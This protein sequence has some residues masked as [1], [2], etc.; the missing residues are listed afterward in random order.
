MKKIF[1][2]F[3]T[4]LL[5]NACQKQIPTEQTLKETTIEEFGTGSVPNIRVQICHQNGVEIVIDESALI[6]HLAHGDAVDGD[7]DGYFDR[8]NPCSVIDCNDNNASVNSGATEICENN[9]DDN[10]DGQID[11][12][13]I[14]FVTICNQ[15]WMSKNLDISTYKNG[16]PIPLVT[17]PSEWAA[18][19]TGAYCYYNNDQATYAA[20]YGKLYNWYAV[21]DSRGLAP[22]GWHIPNDFE[23][24]IL[25]NCLGGATVAGG[26]MKEPGTTHWSTPNTGATNISGFSGLPGGNRGLTGTF[27]GIPGTGYWW[28]STETDASN[29]WYRYLYYFYGDVGRNSYFKLHGFSVRCVRD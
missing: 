5:F 11:E 16:D 8:A 6:A 19:T 14:P 22:E 25:E 24:T 20:T 21:N 28:S 7:N 9:I 13:C 4:I 10:C 1:L 12:N 26:A 17:D 29:A 2:P 3:L 15:T 23:W 27:G 18:L